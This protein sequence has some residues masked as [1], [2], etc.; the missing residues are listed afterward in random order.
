MYIHSTYKFQHANETAQYYKKLLK[1]ISNLN[2]RRS[3]K[4]NVLSVYGALN[5]MKGIIPKKNI[6]IYIG[7]EYGV[8]SGVQKVVKSLTETQSMV[9]PFDFL[10]INGNNAGFNISKAL[11]T[12]GESMLI[13]ASD[14]SFEQTLKLAFFK[15]QQELEFEALIGG[16]DESLEEIENFKEYISHKIEIS[17]DK[18]CWLYC[19]NSSENA[20]A[21]IESIKDFCNEEELIAYLEKKTS[22]SSVKEKYFNGIQNISNLIDLLK[23]DKNITYISYDR[24]NRYILIEIKASLI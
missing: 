21:K 24:N 20:L 1:N 19:S 2:L 10:N 23:E 3:N 22:Y 13:T 8:V 12:Q 18:S 4:F 9:M 7:T 16:V 6:N 11:E 17:Y 5:C 14:F 15:S